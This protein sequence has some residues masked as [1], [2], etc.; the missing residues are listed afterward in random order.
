MMMMFRS[1]ILAAV[2]ALALASC[3][4]GGSSPSP[5]AVRTAGPVSTSSPVTPT[6]PNASARFTITVPNAST[7]TS[8]NKR[9]PK[10]ISSATQSAI[11]TLVSV[12]GAAYTGTPSSI[13]SN[14]T[15][16]NP[17]CTGSPLT[18]TISAPAVAGTDVF[19]VVT[20]DAT[21]TSTSPATPLGHELSRATTSVNVTGGQANTVTTPLVLSGVATSITTSLSPSSVTTGDPANVSVIVNVLDADKNIIMGTYT[22]TNGNPLTIDLANSGSSGA[23]TLSPTSITNSSTSVSLAYNGDQ[24]P[25]VTI[26]PSVS[27]GT[28]TG[29]IAGA[30]LTFTAPPAPTLTELSQKAWTTSSSAS[31]FSE[32][33]TGTNFTPEQ[34]SVTVSNSNIT[35][36]SLTVNSATSITATF[37]VAANTAAG[38]DTVSVTTPGGTTATLPLTIGAGFIVT[39]A[40]DTTPGSPPGTGAGV[41]GDLR[42]ALNQIA[43]G[44]VIVFQCGTAPAVGCAITLAGPL[45]PIQHDVTIDGG[46][47]TLTTIDGANLYRA[48]FVASGRVAIEDL[49]IENVLAK[50]GAGGAG[51]G[52]GGGLGAGAGL[53]MTTGSTVSVSSVA[54]TNPVA[55]GGAGQ[56]SSASIFE[57]KYL[58]YDQGSGGG[59]GGNGGIDPRD[60]G[61]GA[62]GGGVLGSASNV[63]DGATY[64]GHYVV[65]RTASGPVIRSHEVIRP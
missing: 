28:I 31:S 41:S 3:S 35:V 22:D 27:G 12:N 23:T 9:S 50:G 46:G 30:S 16:T 65:E 62:G 25:G 19:T 7:A 44:D 40:G 51:S 8:A 34:T 63:N 61:A 24:T 1:R 60:N 5:S 47:A 39:S 49:Q 37:D 4:G 55:T 43:N 53:F 36:A 11:I 13:A 29:S 33:L 58:F 52:G 20:Y 26:T 64:F 17:N 48:F 38:T 56:D 59:L 54:F 21:Q 6:T 10:Y 32:T 15:T 2:A 14:L 57:G 18:C 42:Y 45:P